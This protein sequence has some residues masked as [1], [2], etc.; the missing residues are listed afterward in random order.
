MYV[1]FCLEDIENNRRL[2][3]RQFS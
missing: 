2:Q 1:S 3:T